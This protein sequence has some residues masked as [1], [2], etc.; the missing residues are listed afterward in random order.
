MTMKIKLCVFCL[1]ASLVLGCSN[2]N[3]NPSESVSWESPNEYAYASDE[4][5]RK[6]HENYFSRQVQKRHGS[7]PL[8]QVS[9]KVKKQQQADADKIIRRAKTAIGTPYVLGGTDMS[10]F[11]CSGFVR[12]AYSSVGVKLPRTAREQSVVGTKIR[13]EKDMQVGDIVTFRH[14]RRGYHTGIYVG[15]GKFIHSP[16]RRSHV[17]INSLDD[18]YFSQTFTGARR[19]DLDGNENLIAQAAS[20]I[21]TTPDIQRASSRSSKRHAKSKHLNKRDKKESRMMLS[22]RDSGRKLKAEKNKA[23]SLKNG[24][25]NSKKS[26]KSKALLSQN[27]KS[28]AK[29][30]AGKKNTHKSVSL[31]SQHK[32]KKVSAKKS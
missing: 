3:Q 27:N 32:S 29:Q 4:T 12:W 2:K 9:R 11:D 20:R 10:G 14:P 13:D 1:F 8:V 19:I 23:V 15:D 16:R 17:K 31:S 24:A 21:D 30:S 5:G 18:S 28:S 26:E 7:K 25:K 6:V 22:S